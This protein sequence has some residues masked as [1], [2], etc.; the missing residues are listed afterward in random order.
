MPSW[1]NREAIGPMAENMQANVDSIKTPIS[2]F[3]MS[4]MIGADGNSM[5]WNMAPS[6]HVLSSLICAL[7]VLRRKDIHVAAR[8]S[9]Y[10]ICSLIVLSTLLVVEVNLFKLGLS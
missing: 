7:G 3:L 9:V 5:A 1:Q 2:K 4:M 10:T 8:V 6:F